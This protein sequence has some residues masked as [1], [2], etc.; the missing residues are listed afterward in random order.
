VVLT[1]I[2]DEEGQWQVSGRS[3]RLL[4][5]AS[6]ERALTIHKGAGSIR[7]R[8]SFNEPTEP[9]QIWRGFLHF[10][11]ELE[12]KLDGSSVI[13]RDPV[14]G[15]EMH[16]AIEGAANRRIVTG[17]DDPPQGWVVQGKEL[18]EAPVLEFEAD[19][20]EE[21]TMAITWS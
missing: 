14:T 1:G 4:D 21:V 13:A 7:V 19:G 10:A 15:R 20:A 12:V 16:I 6:F 17:Q 9:E 5:D 18:L 2:S 3:D 8:D 11:P